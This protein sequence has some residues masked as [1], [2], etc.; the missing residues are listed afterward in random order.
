MKLL[1]IRH[2]QPDY[3]LIKDKKFQG[4]GLDLAPLSEEGK[5]QIKQAAKNPLLKQAEI[6]LSSPYTRALQTAAIISS[7]LQLPIK[8]EIDLHEWIPDKTFTY[9]TKSEMNSLHRDFYRN[10]GVYPPGNTKKWESLNALQTRVAKVFGKY[11][12]TYKTI[13]VTCHS[14]VIKSIAYQRNIDYGELVVAD[15]DPQ[16]P[17]TEWVFE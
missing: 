14:M 17:L 5:N 6:I 1:L 15:Y 2:G 16:K 8:V 9:Q 10:Q 13:I 3:S 11:A 7:N 4:H 12:G